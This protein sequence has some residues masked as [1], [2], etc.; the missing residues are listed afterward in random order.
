ME[1]K[2]GE[3]GK[4]VVNF[5]GG[6]VRWD[7]NRSMLCCHNTP[8]KSVYF[9]APSKKRASWVFVVQTYIPGKKHP[10]W[11]SC[12]LSAPRRRNNRTRTSSLSPLLCHVFV[13]WASSLYSRTDNWDATSVQLLQCGCHLRPFSATVAFELVPVP[14]VLSCGLFESLFVPTSPFCVPLYTSISPL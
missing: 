10:K 7:V 1:K 5:C 12:F 3:N 9:E 2:A 13:G 4:A 8:A 14:F 6:P 11:G